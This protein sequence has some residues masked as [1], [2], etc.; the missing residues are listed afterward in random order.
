[1]NQSSIDRWLTYGG[2]SV[3]GVYYG[4]PDEAIAWRY[5]GCPLLPRI[6]RESEYGAHS[7]PI[8]LTRFLDAPSLTNADLDAGFLHQFRLNE[9]PSALRGV[10]RNLIYDLPIITNYQAVPAGVPLAWLMKLPIQSRTRNVINRIVSSMGTDGPLDVGIS[11]SEFLTVRSSGKVSLVDLL[12]VMESAESLEDAELLGKTNP[13]KTVKSLENLESRLQAEITS[14]LLEEAVGYLEECFLWAVA[15]TDARTIGDAVSHLIDGK[16]GIRDW[17]MVSELK[18][19]TIVDL[20]THP[21]IVLDSWVEHLDE[22]DREIFESRL[23]VRR[24]TLREIGDRWGLTRERVRQIEQGLLSQLHSFIESPEGKVVQWRIYSLRNAIGTATPLSDIEYLLKT[25]DTGLDYRDLLLELAGPYKVSKGWV[26]LKESEKSDPTG[27]ILE[28]T[29]DH[30]CIDRKFATDE[31]SKWRLSSSAHE[32]WLSR[33]GKVR[34]INGHLVR[35][36]TRVQDKLA[37]A[38]FDLGVPSIVETLADYIRSYGWQGS[39]LTVLNSMSSDSRFV[40][41]SKSEWAL[42]SWSMPAYEGIAS[43][44]HDLLKTEGKPMRSDDVVKRLVNEFSLSESSVVSY[45]Y[46]P[47]FVF[48]E[49]WV[50]LRRIDEPYQYPNGTLQSTGGVFSLGPMRVCLLIKVDHDVLRGSGR[51]LTNVAGTLLD[52]RVNDEVIFFGED[53]LSVKINFPATSISGPQMSST[54]LLAESTGAKTGDFLTLILNK[55]DRSLTYRLTRVA[56]VA[57]SWEIVSRLTGIDFDDNYGDAMNTLARGLGCKVEDV[58]N[59]LHKRGDDVVVKA[60]PK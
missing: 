50:R 32:S 17:D 19:D 33:D 16:S 44:I 11:C 54:R 28:R 25:T 30:A 46:A 49:G 14:K 20:P 45:L 1:M 52:I 12:C 8:A 57:S 34:G 6:Y 43:S 23:I 47:M 4:A 56:E 53:G 58:V 41:T 5:P 36:D 48:D 55:L 38:L 10:I 60:L 15:E 37:F 24:R 26:V 18:L 27:M 31:L 13:S 2:F 22:R 7:V 40:R 59:V 51:Q 29:D 42:A 9:L 21:Y 39:T 35:W 3:N